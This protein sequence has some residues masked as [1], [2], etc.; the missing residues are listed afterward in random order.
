MLSLST[1]PPCFPCRLWNLVEGDHGLGP[2]HADPG[3][4]GG[5]AS[6]VAGGSGPWDA[7][8]RP[9]GPADARGGVQADGGQGGADSGRAEAGRSPPPPEGEGAVG[10]ALPPGR[11]LL[12]SQE[13]HPGQ[14]HLQTAAEDAQR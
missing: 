14:P 2:R 4:P 7:R 1:F 9:E 12:Q 11:A 13:P 3:L 5:G 10:R 6:P 8:P